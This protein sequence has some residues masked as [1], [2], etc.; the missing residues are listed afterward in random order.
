MKIEIVLNNL[1]LSSKGYKNRDVYIIITI[2]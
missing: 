2:F 1:V